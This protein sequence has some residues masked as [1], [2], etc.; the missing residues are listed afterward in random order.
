VSATVRL[1]DALRG[2][3]RLRKILDEFLD[4]QIELGRDELER[5]INHEEARA[6][7][8]L[9]RELRRRLNM[10]DEKEIHDGQTQAPRRRA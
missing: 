3:D 6:R 2:N 9:A 5:G 1:A 4:E 7:C 10:A 8:N